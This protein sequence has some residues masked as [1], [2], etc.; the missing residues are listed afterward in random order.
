MLAVRL[1]KAIEVRLERLALR[2]GRT[3]SYYV[4]HAI[5]EFLDEREDYLIAISRMEKREPRVSLDKLAKRLGL[6]D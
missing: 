1:P 5:A 2:T 3:K 6:E 4:R